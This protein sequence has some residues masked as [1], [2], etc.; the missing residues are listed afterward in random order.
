MYIIFLYGDNIS[1]MWRSRIL[2]VFL[3]HN[4]PCAHAK[5][6]TMKFENKIYSRYFVQWNLKASRVKIT[7][8]SCVLRLV[9]RFSGLYNTQYNVFS[10]QRKFAFFLTLETFIHVLLKFSFPKLEQFMTME[11]AADISTCD[12][13]HSFS[14]QRA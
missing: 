11:S 6:G 3:L 4:F 9:P 12:P 8:V 2:I 7:Q 5:N 14:F 10:T 1:D 13:S